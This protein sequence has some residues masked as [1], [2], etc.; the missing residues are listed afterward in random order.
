MKSNVMLTPFIA[1][2]TRA[3]RLRAIYMALRVFLYGGGRISQKWRL[4]A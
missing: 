1:G 4:A 3:A 2:N